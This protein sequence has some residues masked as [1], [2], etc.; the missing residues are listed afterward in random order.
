M[1]EGLRGQS[2]HSSWG[3]GDLSEAVPAELG[4]EGGIG[5]ASLMKRGASM[6][7]PWPQ[8]ETVRSTADTSADPVGI[9]RVK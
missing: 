8:L 6:E 3:V 2:G 7:G 1:R 5:G 4:F 9:Y